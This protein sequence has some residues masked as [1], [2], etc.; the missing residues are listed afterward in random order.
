MNVERHSKAR[1]AEVHWHCDGR[2]AS[3]EVIDDGDGFPQ[4]RAG[5]LDSYGMI[6]MRERASS[7]GATL[8]VQSAL[9]QGTTVRCVLRAPIA[10]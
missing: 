7:I 3:L 8:E 10:D 6:G 1:S 4:G 9:G 2:T 5:R